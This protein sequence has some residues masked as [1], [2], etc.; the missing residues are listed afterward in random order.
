MSAPN[1]R[2]R[3]HACNFRPA[4]AAVERALPR[5]DL[6]HGVIDRGCWRRR[7]AVARRRSGQPWISVGFGWRRRAA[8][9]RHRTRRSFA[10]SADFTARY[11]VDLLRQPVEAAIDLVK[12]AVGFSSVAI[13]IA[14][15]W[16]VAGLGA[17]KIAVAEFVAALGAIEIA[18][19]GLTT[20]LGM[21]EVAVASRARGVRCGCA[22]ARARPGV[23]CAALRLAARRRNR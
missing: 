6:G 20:G 7:G 4:F 2:R 10:A 21:F 22:D 18:V 11:A 5:R 14:A 1:R 12:I 16:F 8:L 13:E 19:A 17:I 9:L 3:R 15:A 23:D